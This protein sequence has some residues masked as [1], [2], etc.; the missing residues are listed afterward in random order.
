MSDFTKLEDVLNFK[1][2]RIITK[3]IEPYDVI[4][5]AKKFYDVTDYTFTGRN[6]FEI[7]DNFLTELKSLKVAGMGLY[8]KNVNKFYLLKIKENPENKTNIELLHSLLI[9]EEYG[10]SEDE[11][12]NK[13]GIEYSTNT[14]YALEQ[15]DMGK[16]EASFIL[17]QK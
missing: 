3:R 10:F 17:I 6:K 11:Q 5:S 4:E 14:D 13:Q 15:I 1:G 7:L 16:A 9:S 12:I 8:M 2:N